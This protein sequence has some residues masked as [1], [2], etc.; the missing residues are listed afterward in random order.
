M[1]GWTVVDIVMANNVTLGEL[2]HGVESD[3]RLFWNV[4]C[5]EMRKQCGIEVLFNV[6]SG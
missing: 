2:R 4:R 6:F 3:D 5:E 1:G